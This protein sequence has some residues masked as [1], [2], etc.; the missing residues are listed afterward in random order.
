MFRSKN[1]S[2]QSFKTSAFRKFLILEGKKLVASLF[3]SPMGSGWRSWDC[4]VWRRGGSGE[5]LFLSIT[6]WREVTVSWGSASSPV[7][8]VIGLQG[9]ASSCAREGSDW[10]L[11]NATSLKGWSGTGMGCPERWWSHWPWRCSRN[12]WMLCW[13]TWVSENH[14]WWANF[15]TGWSCGSFPTLAILWFYELEAL[16]GTDYTSESYYT[17]EIQQQGN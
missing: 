11:G 2:A 12:I 6:T 5:T 13:G 4:S 7:W 8:L 17:P 1:V 9:T 15:W 16:W 3:T 14:W 10:M